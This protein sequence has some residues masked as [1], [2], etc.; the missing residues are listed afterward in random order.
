MARKKMVDRVK[1]LAI[2]IDP[3]VGSDDTAAE[4]AVGI[5][6]WL[7][8]NPGVQVVQICYSK[9]FRVALIHYRKPA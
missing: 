4:Q 9:N 8:G 1:H 7:E 6:A 2:V 3:N 5:N